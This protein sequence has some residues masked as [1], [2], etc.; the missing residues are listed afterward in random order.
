MKKLQNESPLD[1]TVRIALGV[2]LFLIALGLV[3]TIKIIV[4]LVAIVLVTTGIAGFCP[5]Y[6]LL[7]IRTIKK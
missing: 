3:G 4:L 7:G 1:R 2:V 6:K 5:L